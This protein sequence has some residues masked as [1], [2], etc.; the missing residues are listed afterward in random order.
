MNSILYKLLSNKAHSDKLNKEYVYHMLDDI[1]TIKFTYL[2]LYNL[3]NRYLNVFKKMNLINKKKF[4]IVDNSIDSIAIF[5]A[6]LETK[7]IP[8]LINK[9]TILSS[10][11]HEGKDNDILIDEVFKNY[12]YD[13]YLVDDLHPAVKKSTMM[14]KIKEYIDNLVK[15][16]ITKEFINDKNY[17]YLCTSGTTD[18][19]SKPVLLN[20]KDLINKVFNDFK[21]CYNYNYYGYTTI[22]SISG[23][24]FNVILPIVLNNK[25]Y[26]HGRY[27]YTSSLENIFN[28][29]ERYKINHLV[30]P[31]DIYKYFPNSKSN[32][33]LSHLKKIYLS[34]EVN[35]LKIIKDM[36]SLFNIP[37]NVFC[38]LYGSTE[39][40]GVI[41]I[42]KEQEI[43]PLYVSNISFF[44]NKLIYTFDKVNFYEIT[45]D[46]GKMRKRKINM[47][48]KEEDFYEILPVSSKKVCKLEL[49]NIDN[50]FYKE[51][52][53]KGINN[54][55]IG[56]TLN[57][58]LYILGRRKDL[59][60][61]NDNYYFIPLIE[62]MF[63]N[64]T[65]YKASCILNEES[66][67]FLI[68]IDYKIDD[69][70]GDNFKRLLPLAK[71]CYSL[72]EK[73]KDIFKVEGLMFI[74][75]NIFPRSKAM[76]K[77]RKQDLLKFSRNLDEFNYNVNNYQEALYKKIKGYIYELTNSNIDF[78]LEERKVIFSKKDLSFSTIA[79]LLKYCGFMSYNE[80][81]DSFIIEID[82]LCF[83]NIRPLIN[84]RNFNYEHSINFLIESYNRAD[85]IKE[86]NRELNRN[87][88]YINIKMSGK[89]IVNSDGVTF[90]PYKLYSSDN[91]YNLDLICETPLNDEALMINEEMTV[92]LE[93]FVPCI[94]YENMDYETK[95]NDYKK[96]LSH[97]YFIPRSLRYASVDGFIRPIKSIPMYPKM[98]AKLG[99]IR[100]EANDVK[101]NIP[102]D[103]A[104]LIPNDN[105]KVLN[106]A[107]SFSFRDNF[108][109]IDLVDRDY[110]HK[111]DNIE[112]LCDK[113]AFHFSKSGLYLDYYP[114]VINDL[115]YAKVNN[116]TLLSGYNNEKILVIKDL[117]EKV[118]KHPKKIYKVNTKEEEFDFSKIRVIY[119]INDLNL[120]QNPTKEQMKRLN[121]VDNL[122]DIIDSKYIFPI[123]IL[124]LREYAKGDD[125]FERKSKSL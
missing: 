120:Y 114:I 78:I 83:F 77:V 88:R 49:I 107:P 69:L 125:C 30:L 6:L 26:F 82:D 103:N 18:G 91:Y 51:L 112:Y 89:Y 4:I 16:D 41:S 98:I 122:R 2:D 84:K 17:F 64:A 27:F 106:F 119:V 57:Q 76:K 97:K 14:I 38:N 62:R 111:M 75:S 20:E 11:R 55:D 24:I 92:D 74:P 95:I 53:I 19:I 116:Q 46:K 13:Y 45:Y 65:G 104:L 66:S 42:C 23:M 40:N 73:N 60:K 56:F 36:R 34:G 29:L 94:F 1:D 47:I 86:F 90:F 72:I 61:V 8:I 5:I 85:F 21:G 15:E 70:K 102:L 109:C 52:V 67:K 68:F 80:T 100:I 79:W 3:V 50:K 123:D 48:Y 35:D 87:K 71:K 28:D 12:M 58:K 25:I 93:Y 10:L 44:S 124:S 121:Y 22:A 43:K 33:D 99:F 39:N 59:Q 117:F 115:E 9:E 105:S 113:I 118:K 32:L 7:A 81:E 110:H 31:R 96:L 101:Y 63:S 54:G 108:D 37:A